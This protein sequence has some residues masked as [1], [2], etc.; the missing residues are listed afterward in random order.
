ML[1]NPFT[2]RSGI[3]PRVFVGREDELGFFQQDRLASAIRGKCM[4]YVITGTWGIGKTVLL[5][6]MK[7]SAQ[8]TGAW[9]LLFSTRGFR[10]K[11]TLADF[12]AH[13]LDMAAADLPIQPKRKTQSRKLEGA[14]ASAFGFGLQ[15]KW[16]SPSDKRG[17]DPQL[18][19]REGL[20]QM[21]DHAQSQGAKALVLMIDDV[22]NL[23]ADGQELTLLRNVLTDERIVSK[24]KILVILS[25]ID[26]GWNPFLVRDHPVGRLFMPRRSLGVFDR[27]ETVKLIDESLHSTGVTF[28]GT[29]KDQVYELTHGHVFEVQALCEA[30]FDRQVK[31]KVTMDNWEPALHHTLL[32]LAEAQFRG[33]FE[34]ASALE[35]E[36]LRV[37]ASSS[38]VLGPRALEE[39][40]PQIKGAAEVLKRLNEKGLAERVR[41]GE[42]QISDRLFAEYVKRRVLTE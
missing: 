35:I 16:N 23:S 34:R 12:A 11:E 32:A 28:D 19:L 33:M 20:V 36:A 30:L 25:S 6:Q 42:Y 21:H 27:G 13:V 8:K 40:N 2:A 41:R 10:A 37:L 5:R 15:V 4:H 24:T 14:G 31:G 17:R 3:D 9:A 1:V 26:Q 38:E 7:L 39:R 18:L 29:V 22:Q